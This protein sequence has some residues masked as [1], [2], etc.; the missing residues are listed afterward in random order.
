MTPTGSGNSTVP[1]GRDVPRAAASRCW[2][3][4]S[5]VTALSPV[6]RTERLLLRR[7][8]ESDAPR[9]LAIHGRLDVIRW[10]SNPPF[11][12]MPDL[13]AARTW[14]HGV[15]ARESDDPLVG[16]RAVEVVDTGVVA[17]SVLVAHLD[18]VDGGFVGEYQIGWHL[19]PDSSGHGYATE[20]A[21]ALA[22]A[23]FAAGHEELLVDMY[24]DNTPSLRVALRLGAE[25]RGD[26]AEDPW[27]GGPGRVLALR[28]EHLRAAGRPAPSGSRRGGMPSPTTTIRT[29]RLVLRPF[30]TDDAD[31]LFD[32]FSRPE[33]ARWSGTGTVMTQRQEAVDRIARMP[34]RAGPHPAAG[35]F[36]VCPEGSER[37]VGMAVLVPIPSSHGVDRDDLEI[38]WHLHP[39]AWGHGYATEAATALV[40]RARDAGVSH[41]VA[42]TDPANEA[43]Q[44]VCR[45]LG[46]SD[47]G[48]RDDWY[49]R[50][51]RAFDLPL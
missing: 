48:L 8:E 3:H 32:V 39:D 25:D 31:A 21:A 1:A 35:V 12:P 37:P 34:E 38:G 43:S 29:E 50:T 4:A 27:Y 42:V 36:A 40:E 2:W 33:V 15:N 30:T 26:V 13:D 19:H 6:V 18:R 20:A 10:L 45:R 51:L 44:A 47:L 9:V 17:G 11:V 24:P 49:D 7:Y 5:D 23:A 22:H 14:V 46:M 16:W 28:P 41:V